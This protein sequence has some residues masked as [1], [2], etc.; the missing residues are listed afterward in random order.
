[1]LLGDKALQWYDDEVASP[2]RTRTHWTFEDVIIGIFDHCVQ[3]STVQEAATQFD[4]VQ[5]DPKK[6]IKDYYNTL[7]RWAG[8]ITNIPDKFTFKRQFVKGLPDYLIREMTKRGSIPD[9]ATV[10]T[11]VKTVQ[12]YETDQSLLSYYLKQAKHSSVRSNRQSDHRGPPGSGSANQPRPNSPTREKA[13]IVNGRRYTLVRRSKSPPRYKGN[14]PTHQNRPSYNDRRPT[15]NPP[16]PSGGNSGNAKPTDKKQA[17]CFGCGGV[18][19]YASDPTCPQYGKPC[20]FATAEDESEQVED[21]NENPLLSDDNNEVVEVVETSDGEYVLE[22]YEDYGGYINGDESD[23]DYLGMIHSGDA[24]HISL[25]DFYNPL[26][27]CGPPVVIE[28]DLDTAGFPTLDPEQNPYHLNDRLYAIDPKESLDTLKVDVRLRRSSRPMNR[29][30][31]GGAA[32]RRPL[33][34]LVEI[35]GQTA[36]TLFGSG[37]TLE[38]MSPGFARL[39]NVKVHQLAEQHSLQLGTVGSRAKFNY[40]TIAS[41]EYS[42]I[43][44]HTYF[45][46]VNIDRYDAIVGTYFMRKHGITL[47]FKK[48]QILVNGTVATCLSVGEDAAELKRRSA[49]R[50]EMKSKDLRRKDNPN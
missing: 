35:A 34:A 5:Y 1:M 32:E 22:E 23:M 40:G 29:P 4:N 31:R 11:M 19:H 44:D 36:L 42:T 26:E 49:M 38:C 47:D 3:M 27:D 30:N 33:V 39:A 24:T 37:C 6:G 41:T 7:C 17:I 45:D 20:L 12:R 48:D 50:R 15:G 43:H 21:V 8:Q 18:G 16:K 46:I 10:R 14:R 25:D 2:H 9:Y 13:R 28:D